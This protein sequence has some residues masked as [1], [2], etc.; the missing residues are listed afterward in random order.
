MDNCALKLTYVNNPL[1]LTLDSAMKLFLGDFR[2]RK[3]GV[4]SPQ[5]FVAVLPRIDMGMKI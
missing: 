5:L 1:V 3:M 2:L 4:G